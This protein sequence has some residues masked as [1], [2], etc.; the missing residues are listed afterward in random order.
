MKDSATNM[1]EEVS[2][3]IGSEEGT[4][5]EKLECTGDICYLDFKVIWKKQSFQVA[6]D[7]GKKIA[8]LKEHIKDLTGKYSFVDLRPDVSA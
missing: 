5:L 2:K 4:A 3:M 1:L 8:D 7:S 6:F